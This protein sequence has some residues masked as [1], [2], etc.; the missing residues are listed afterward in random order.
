MWAN[1]KYQEVPSQKSLVLSPKCCCPTPNPS[2]LFLRVHAHQ[3]TAF[4]LFYLSNNV[5]PRSF[6][7]SRSRFCCSREGTGPSCAARC[8]CNI[9]HH[10]VG[11]EAFP[12][13]FWHRKHLRQGGISVLCA[14]LA[15]TLLA[16]SSGHRKPHSWQTDWLQPVQLYD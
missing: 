10:P 4:F 2:S 14:N 5:P 8:H 16:V 7:C 11:R 3:P 6:C 9:P 15:R 13:S 1:A 12:V